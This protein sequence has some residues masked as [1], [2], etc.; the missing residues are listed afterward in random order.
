MKKCNK[1]KKYKLQ[2]KENF[3]PDKRIKSGFQGICR[4]CQKDSRKEYMATDKYK[5][6]RKKYLKEN[7]DRIREQ[8][9][10]YYRREEYK[11]K[12]RAYQAMYRDTDAGKETDKKFRESEKSIEYQKSYNKKYGKM[13]R[14]QE[15]YNP[16][17][18]EYMKEY[19]K[20]NPRTWKEKI[21]DTI[22]TALR[23]Q[24]KGKKEG[25]KWE[26]IIGYSVVELKEHLE[27]Q[28]EPW[29]TWENHGVAKHGKRRWQIDHIIPKHKF[30]FTSI[31]DENIKKCW[32]LENL[33]PLEAF[34]NL[35]KGG[36][37]S[38]T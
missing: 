35:K 33:R 31:N 37:C 4:V 32:A 29:M 36:S 30:H 18:R 20:R 11:K 17:M 9:K 24:L 6:A 38:E 13:I 21:N 3:A 7:Q 34:E 25:T 14:K 1:C 16:W 27:K 8:R 26:K 15:W 12:K 19:R 28:F 10:P 22:S 5:D 2:N 23:K